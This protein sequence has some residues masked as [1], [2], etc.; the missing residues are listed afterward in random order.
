MLQ[1]LRNAFKIKDLRKRFLFTLIMLIITRLGAQIP[2]PGVSEGVFDSLFGAAGDSMNFFDAITGGSLER[3]SIFALS[4]TPYITS[5]IIIQLLTIA[6]P[7][8]E[9]ISR[10]GERGR[11]IITK[12]TRDV[13]VGL[14]LMES[15]AMAIG[16]G[17]SGYLEKIN[18]LSV[19]TL[20]T[21]LTAG[22]TILMWIGERITEK[23]IGNGIS[24]VL[25]I[26]IVSRMPQDITT[27]FNQFIKGKRVANGILSGVIIAAVIISI[28]FMVVVLQGAER[29][30]P[31]QY[32]KMLRG[33]KTYGGQSSYIP[34]K[35][36]TGG[37]MPVIFAQSLM[38]TPVMICA[39]LGVAQ[40]QG[41][42]ADLLRSM[43]ESNWFNSAN[44]IYSWGA[45]LY[46]ILIIIFA[47]FYT[48]ITFNPLEI[49]D[50]MKK[51]GG[52]IPGIRPGKAT[53]D[54]LTSILNY[55]IFIGAIGLSIVSMLPIIL[56]G[57]F[58]AHVSFGGTSIIIVVG[59]VI[60]TLQQVESQMLVRNYRGFLSE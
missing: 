29:K 12:I 18:V 19:L 40:G 49:A 51:S 38:Q 54:Y 16:F 56:N 37:V 7:K 11:K 3:M 41:F 20:I 57:L 32:S 34:L 48:S 10:D 43:S 25:I 55:I 50:N 22:S 27:L 9:E 30:I 53:S 17:R 33:N 60:E 24:I 5:S 35:V 52:F 2:A 8:L 42:W 47:Y 21:V 1:T 31:V 13:S 15:T 6:F 28:V 14:A 39:F 44:W 58:N 46:L 36:N 23:G 26:N 59:V 4:I 45:L